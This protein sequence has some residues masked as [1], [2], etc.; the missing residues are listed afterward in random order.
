MINNIE[1]I[2][3]ITSGFFYKKKVI[4]F[5]RKKGYR[6]SV[7]SPILADFLPFSPN[8][9]ALEI[10]TGSGIIS[11]LALYKNKFSFIYGIEIQN[12]LSRLAK[13]N[14]QKN[15]LNEKF[16]V[17]NADFNEIYKDFSEIKIIFSNPP[18]KTT[19]IGRLS[20]NEEIRIS[21]TEIKIRL[22]ELLEK[23]FSILGEKGSLYL[24]LPYNR[25]EELIQLTDDIGYS[26]SMLRYIL[27]F[28]DGKIER[29]L[30]QLTNYRGSFKEL[31]PLIVF[32]NKGVYTNE[33][34]DILSGN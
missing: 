1:N 33:M 5:Q 3:D 30:I 24:I 8:D 34:E 32:K 18:F 11:L 15:N 10:G 23:S 25:Y 28:K 26:V 7:D 6:F 16:K 4:V 21:K 13:I 14:I 19:S 20:P 9:N 27:S 12:K 2:D 29:F 22:K 17:I 31:K